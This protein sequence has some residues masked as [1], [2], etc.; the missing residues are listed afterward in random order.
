MSSA[1]QNTNNS[2]A[3]GPFLRVAHA[4]SSIGSFSTGNS[5]GSASFRRTSNGGNGNTRRTGVAASSSTYGRSKQPSRSA[6]ASRGSAS[7][8]GAG[9]TFLPQDNTPHRPLLS[10][11]IY[12]YEGSHAASAAGEIVSAPNNNTPSEVGQTTGGEAI[13]PIRDYDVV[14]GRNNNTQSGGEAISPIRDYDVVIGRNSSSGLSGAGTV[15]GTTTGARTSS[16]SKGEL[17]VRNSLKRQYTGALAEP[18]LSEEEK[19]LAKFVVENELP[20]GDLHAGDDN[21]PQVVDHHGDDHKTGAKHLFHYNSYRLH[22]KSFQRLKNSLNTGGVQQHH[23]R[24]YWC[25]RNKYEFVAFLDSFEVLV[26][27]TC[28]M[29]FCLMLGTFHYY[30]SM[31][32]AKV[33]TDVDLHHNVYEDDLISSH[34]NIWIDGMYWAVVTFT[35]VGYGDVIP[36]SPHD[37]QN[38]QHLCSPDNA[39]YCHIDETMLIVLIWYMVVSN[40]LIVAILGNY[41]VNATRQSSAVRTGIYRVTLVVVYLIVGMFGFHVTDGRSS[42]HEMFYFVSVTSTTV[43]YGDFVPDG[44]DGKLF[45][46]V[47]ITMSTIV[48]ASSI[49]GLMDL[50]VELRNERS[51]RRFLL[52]GDIKREL[53]RQAQLETGETVITEAEY[54]Y[55]MLTQVNLCT[56]ATVTAL[57]LSFEMVAEEELE[58]ELEQAGDH[59]PQHNLTGNVDLAKLEHLAA[60]QL[61]EGSV[62]D[63]DGSSSVARATDQAG[64]SRFSS[65][66]SEYQGLLRGNSTTSAAGVVTVDLQAGGADDQAEEEVD[67]GKYLL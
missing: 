67:E 24:K 5:T 58:E 15:T 46:I 35:T 30:F 54:I 64:G 1:H 17:P 62:Y 26:A 23:Q 4:R 65:K 13:S 43:G 61:P 3:S 47:Y 11:D 41:M 57:R 40:I 21:T 9:S 7:G 36:G 39:S 18:L 32:T 63:E 31:S 28:Y 38:P 60:R 44:N 42:A 10:E 33:Y 22:K 49:A 45:A 29:L 51:V 20:V 56:P 34:R 14:I 37:K 52:D 12:M 8:S 6:A 50:F 19:Q 2:A 66:V 53:L 27:A 16:G 25:R 48:V 55:F 59:E